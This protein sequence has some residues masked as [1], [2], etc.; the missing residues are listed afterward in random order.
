MT[1]QRA[2]LF[3]YAETPVHPGGDTGACAV[4]LPIQREVATGLPIIKGESLKGAL[5]EHFRERLPENQWEGMFGSKPPRGGGNT[6]PG[7]LRVHEAQLVAFPAP[8]LEGTFGW[9]TSPLATTRLARTAGLAGIQ[10]A[11]AGALD[12]DDTTC[13]TSSRRRG[14]T[15][16]GQYVQETRHDSA[17]GSFATAL[18]ELALPGTVDDYLKMKLG[19]DLWCGVDGLLGAISRDCAPIVARVQLGAE[20]DDGNPTKTVQHGPFYS[21][22]LPSET[23]LVALLEGRPQDLAEMAELDSGVLRVGGDESIGKGLIWCRLHL[24]VEST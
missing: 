22:Y 6:R 11:A 24:G 5:R 15:V 21:E 1:L 13:L 17:L 8:T 9:V 3:M 12:P 2:L 14:K 19:K 16:L 7:S 4:D 23:L 10:I 20:D 18:A